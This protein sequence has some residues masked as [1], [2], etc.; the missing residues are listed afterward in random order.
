MSLLLGMRNCVNTYSLFYFYYIIIDNAPDDTHPSS[1]IMSSSVV[2][3]IPE[4]K[5]AENVP[6][7]NTPI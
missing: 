7:P 2:I 1:I 6:K 5:H 4:H 3:G